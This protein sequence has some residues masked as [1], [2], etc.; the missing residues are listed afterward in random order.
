M[1]CRITE[2]R[3]DVWLRKTEKITKWMIQWQ[4]WLLHIF[5]SHGSK[6]NMG[7]KIER[8]QLILY[9][10]AWQASFAV[11]VK[12]KCSKAFPQG[13]QSR[14]FAVNWK[15]LAPD[16]SRSND[17]P[18]FHRDVMDVRS[19]A[20]ICPKED[21]NLGMPGC[22]VNHWGVIASPKSNSDLRW[23]ELPSGS[24]CLSPLVL[25]GVTD[26][27]WMPQVL[28]LKCDKHRH[29]QTCYLG[30]IPSKPKEVLTVSPRA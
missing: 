23:A 5:I 7:K 26:L 6:Q 30:L 20:W 17:L 10:F 29:S 15:S 27:T 9:P 8:R 28:A 21:R 12:V 22:F 25:C 2:C 18:S 16:H 3:E 13:S 11:A 14:V 1:R 19:E 24:L 4:H